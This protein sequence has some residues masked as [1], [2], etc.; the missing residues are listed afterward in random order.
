MT[1]ALTFHLVPSSSATLS[2][3]GLTGKPIQYGTGLTGKEWVVGETYQFVYNGTAFVAMSSYDD[4]VV[5]TSGSGNA[6]TSISKTGRSITAI[7]GSTFLTAHP[8][9]TKTND[10]TSTQTVAHSGTF[11]VIDSVT[12]D[13]NGHVTKVNT[14]TITLPSAGTSGETNQNA[15][16]KVTIGT[17]TIEADAKTD[18][19]TLVAGSN[20]TLTPDATNDKITIEAT[21]TNTHYESKNVVGDSAST[22]S[23]AAAMNGNVYL[24]H[25]ENNKT[26]T[27]SHKIVGTGGTSVAC[28]SNGNITINSPTIPTTIQGIQG[29]Q[30]VQGFQGTNGAVTTLASSGSGNG[31]SS[32]SLS[33]GKITQTLTNF[34]PGTNR[35]ATINNLTTNIII[36]GVYSDE[37]GIGDT[38]SGFGFGHIDS[39]LT[40]HIS[41]K[42]TVSS[43]GETG[44]PFNSVNA[45][46]GCFVQLCNAND[47]T[48]INK[49]NSTTPIYLENGQFKQCNTEITG[50][51]GIQGIQGYTGTAAGFGTP[52]ATISNTV[53]TPSVTITTSGSNTAKVFNFAFTNL[54][55]AQGAQGASG[56]NIATTFYHCYPDETNYSWDISYFEGVTLQRSY[57]V[58]DIDLF[59]ETIEVICNGE[60]S[61]DHY[62]LLCNYNSQD[63]DVVFAVGGKG[64]A[65]MYNDFG[66][67]LTVPAYSMIEVSA[68]IIHEQHANGQLALILTRSSAIQ[69]Q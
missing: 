12:R 57:T 34:V 37:E 7:Q 62:L 20:I 48:P 1:F 9:I 68:V 47:Q 56:S 55:G 17:T 26:L 64:G 41:P 10:T 36:P 40:S 69:Q 15:F 44:T 60:T 54:K 63:I 51:Q 35:A 52:T 23:N 27:S 13:T 11:T 59:G 24:N 38:T 42:G 45:I 31:V 46:Q 66:Q 29:I 6:I 50:V 3:N 25:V 5:T 8:T 49:G 19:L 65:T 32:L 18:T 61:F 58:W 4:Y 2:V 30:G 43:I 22:M 39:I 67:I 14:K 16:S 33:N 21:D 53:G 28:D